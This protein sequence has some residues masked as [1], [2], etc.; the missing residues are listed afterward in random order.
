MCLWVCIII[1]IKELVLNFGG[2]WGDMRGA[3]R[4]RERM[5]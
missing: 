3:G 2:N 1:K 5:E 4:E